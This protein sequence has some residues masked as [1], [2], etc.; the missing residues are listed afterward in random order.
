M[1]V[2]GLWYVKVLECFDDG[3]VG[4]YVGVYFLF[5]VGV[6]FGVGIGVGNGVCLI[7]FV[8]VLVWSWFMIVIVLDSECVVMVC[9]I[10]VC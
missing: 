10:E 3:G 6:L 5:L 4:L 9:L 1:V 2:L 8:L 7:M